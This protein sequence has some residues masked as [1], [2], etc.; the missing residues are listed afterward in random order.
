MVCL[1]NMCMNTLH[2]GDNDDDDDNDNNNNNIFYVSVA[3]FFSVHHGV[4]KIYRLELMAALCEFIII[5]IIINIYIF[6]EISV[7]IHSMCFRF[8][9]VYIIDYILL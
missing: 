5:I 3:I 1:G 7:H 9:P 8:S 4:F 2:K 6:F